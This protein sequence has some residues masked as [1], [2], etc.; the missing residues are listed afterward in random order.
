MV[1]RVLV[2]PFLKVFDFVE[3]ILGVIV[4]VCAENGP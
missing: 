3:L 1:L 2:N 4:L